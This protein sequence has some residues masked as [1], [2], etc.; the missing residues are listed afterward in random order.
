[1]HTQCMLTTQSH[2]EKQILFL[3]AFKRSFHA[4]DNWY[5]HRERASSCL[6]SSSS[7]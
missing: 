6:L 7:A 4:C 3:A 2:T 1:M 5:I